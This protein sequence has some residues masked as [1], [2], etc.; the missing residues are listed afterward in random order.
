M[1]HFLSKPWELRGSVNQGGVDKAPSSEGIPFQDGTSV[2]YSTNVEVY[3][4][5]SGEKL[6]RRH[7]EWTGGECFVFE[8]PG[9]AMEGDASIHEKIH[10]QDHRD[11]LVDTFD[12]TYISGSASK[13]QACFD[14]FLNT[15]YFFRRNI[16]KADRSIPPTVYWPEVLERVC[17]YE[18]KDPA[19]QASIV[20]LAHELPLH[21][22]KVTRQPRRT[23]KRIRDQERI[24]RVRE[25]DKACLSNLARRA[26]IASAVNGGPSQT[27]L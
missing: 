2:I 24:Q 19:R 6:N 8:L 17:S 16:L 26:G 22:E 4:S 7:F 27:I 18:D 12:L 9:P 23:L 15:A 3:C 25:M 21:L 14:A 5:V 1:P 13:P 11:H 10:A 20:D